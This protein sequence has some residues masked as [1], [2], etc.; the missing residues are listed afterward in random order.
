MYALNRAQ[1]IG[2]LTQAPEIRQTP[3]GQMVGDLN[4]VAKQAFMNASGQSS[5]GISFINVVVWRG[6]AEISDKYLKKGSQVFISGRIQT[7]EWEDPEGNKRYKTRVVADEMILLDPRT[8]FTPMGDG[9]MAAGGLNRAE[10]IGNVTRDPEVRQTPGGDSVCTFG[11][12]TNFNWKDRSGADQEKTEFHN[13]VVWGQLAKDISVSVRKGRKVFVS[14]RLQTRSWETPDGQKRWTTEIVAENA[15]A[16]GTVDSEIGAPSSAMGQVT[17]EQY[18][19][20]NPT[21]DLAT[22]KVTFSQPVIKSE[23]MAAGAAAA[24][25]TATG[26]AAT[27]APVPSVVP[28]NPTQVPAIN[29]EPEIKPED[30]P[31]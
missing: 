24:E 8:P 17:Q 23:A 14:G 5:M 2:H 7:D 11:V 3:T 16:L 21:A 18:A 20:A 9:S 30:L 26:V 27:G 4:I 29:Y 1:I 22:T 19:T 13:V 31:F 6:L 25:A 12:A 28:A 15:L 10:V